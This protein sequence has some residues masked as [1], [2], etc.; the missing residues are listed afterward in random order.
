MTQISRDAPAQ[1]CTVVDS[2]T[3][4]R[5]L[6]FGIFFFV[7]GGYCWLNF[8]TLLNKPDI[9]FCLLVSL[10]MIILFPLSISIL[11]KFRVNRKGY[12]IDTRNDIFEFPGGGIEAENWLSYF[13]PTYIFQGYMR[14]QV[15]L[16]T[17]REIESYVDT[18]TRST[19][20]VE[21]GRT[22]RGNV[23]TKK[24]KL[25]MSGDFGALS[26]VFSSKGKRDQLYSAIVSLNKMGDP[27]LR[28]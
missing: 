10:A 25:D 20:I 9:I 8:K 2:P 23:T 28:R 4:A 11:L 27:M 6:I 12:I 7:T 22:R 1:S 17:I 14:H 24:N 26:F 5:Q 21:D 18:S 15:Q 13:S 16:S 3:V 19:Y